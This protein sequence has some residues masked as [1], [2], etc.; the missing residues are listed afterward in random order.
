MANSKIE[1]ILAITR[2]L[3]EDD[4]RDY[5][6]TSGDSLDDVLKELKFYLQKH[7]FYKDKT[8]RITEHISNLSNGDFSKTLPISENEDE[9]DVIC[10]GLNTFAD[11]LRDNA[12]SIKAFD[13]VFNSFKTPFFILN[14]KNKTIT[15]F[16]KSTLDFFNYT[17]SNKYQIPISEILD[18]NL[19]KM[20]ESLYWDKNRKATIQNS[21]KNK[22]GKW[23]VN[24]SKLDSV[25]Y[26]KS[27]IAVFIND[28]TDEFE[29]QQEIK[30]IIVRTIV[31]TQEK[32]RIRFAKDIHDSLG[33]QLSAVS[34]YLSS[35][36]NNNTFSTKMGNKLLSTSNEA[37]IGVLEE[38]RNICFNLM[39][40]TLENYGLV[41]A[42]YELCRKI[43]FSKILVFH[44][45][46]SKNFP[47]LNKSLEIAVFRIIQEF[48]NNSIK[49]GQAKKINIVLKN[50]L[51]NVKLSLQ[52]NG[53]G[54]NY[55]KI[56]SHPG[57]GLKNVKSR[58]ESYNGD[59]NIISSIKKGT[60]Y[61]ITIPVNS[62][63]KRK[64]Q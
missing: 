17:K 31:D 8:N 36:T 41:E 32:E 27:S 4:F 1:E 9:L 10:M 7:L 50:N 18:K 22:N 12:I 42:I 21:F 40:K 59:V 60:K 20:I 6:I 46:I 30:N 62:H 37:L 49:H 55:K 61:E 53:I 13:D 39:P 24:F 43:E 51:N 47:S 57:M 29:K 3:N 35:L 11:E 15:K 44:I 23:I 48:I 28:V 25:Y 2:K 16:N 45:K 56:S 26:Q 52:D 5:P 19:I 34:F 63:F 14:K 64:K 54:F 33:Q 38:I 58:V